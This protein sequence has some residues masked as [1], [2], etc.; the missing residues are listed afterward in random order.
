[1]SRY[2]Q[3]DLRSLE[4]SKRVK[5]YSRPTEL[6]PVAHM[7]RVGAM[8]VIAADRFDTIT[9]AEMIG[10]LVAYCY[11]NYSGG[12]GAAKKLFSASGTSRWRRGLRSRASA[13]ACRDGRT[14]LNR[15][16]LGRLVMRT[17]AK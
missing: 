11:V 12:I 14:A 3:D 1:M 6:V 9:H 16:S 7:I 17:L 10:E 2:L 15:L 5:V 8:S 4:D 13:N